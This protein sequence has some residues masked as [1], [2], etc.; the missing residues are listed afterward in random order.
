MTVDIKAIESSLMNYIDFA[1][2]KIFYFK[3]LE[4]GTFL[5]VCFNSMEGPQSFLVSFRVLKLA[6]QLSGIQHK[7]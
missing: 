2:H 6:L 4:T 5:D 3:T 1:R 7:R